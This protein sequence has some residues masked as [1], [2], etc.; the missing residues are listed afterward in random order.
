MHIKDHVSGMKD[1]RLSKPALEVQVRNGRAKK[2][3]AEQ[4]ELQQTCV[5]MFVEENV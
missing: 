2:K 4:H 1:K 3:L 5:L